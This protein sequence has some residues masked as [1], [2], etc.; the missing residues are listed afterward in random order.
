MDNR[1]LAKVLALAASD[2]DAEA[3]HAL[4]TARRLL[5]SDGADFVELA[6]RL[7]DGTDPADDLIQDLEDTVFELRNDLHKLRAENERLKKPVPAAEPAP[8]GLAQVAEAT[9]EIIRLRAHLADLTAE[10]DIEQAEALRLR[11]SVATLSRKLEEAAA[12]AVGLASRLSESD[13]RRHRLDVEN[14]RLDCLAR[15]LAAELEA[16]TAERDRLSTELLAAATPH[17]VA[18][19]R[20]ARRAT[21]RKAAAGGGQYAL[22]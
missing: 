1:K 13:G 12:E 18:T 7:S 21:G 5:E 11:S 15:A 17:P 6:R 9:A 4:R 3:L 2:N 8:V 22:F 14:R 16:R 10:L 19:P 20:R